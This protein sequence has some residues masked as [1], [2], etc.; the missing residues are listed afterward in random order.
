MPDEYC[1]EIAIVDL[2][3]FLYGFGGC[4]HANAA[5]HP[6][7]ERFLRLDTN[8]LDRG[9]ET[10]HLK[11]PTELNGYN[12]GVIPLGFLN[13]DTYEFMVFGGEGDD[14]FMQRS[15]LFTTSVKDF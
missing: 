1:F 5:P 10:Q 6:Y 11:N 8:H 15:C 4:T 2:R 7:A 9:W 12:Y 14:G 3:H 13:D